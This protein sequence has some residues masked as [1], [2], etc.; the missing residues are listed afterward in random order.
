M[1]DFKKQ[2]K[3][4]ETIIDRHKNADI[5]VLEFY[6]LIEE[7]KTDPA[8]AVYNVASMAYY[9]GIACGYRLRQAEEQKQ[10]ER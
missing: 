8:N 4:G 3:Q 5:S 9:A 6:Q 1:R 7:A 10:K 2:K